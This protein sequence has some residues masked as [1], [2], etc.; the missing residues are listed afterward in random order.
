MAIRQLARVLQFQYMERGPPAQAPAG[1]LPP[2]GTEAAQSATEVA[3][4]GKFS[5]VTLE[6]VRKFQEVFA[7]E[8]QWEQVRHVGR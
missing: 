5:H 7:A 1:L 2:P 8:R 3:A 4:G 6:E